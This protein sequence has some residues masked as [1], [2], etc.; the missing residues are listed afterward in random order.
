MAVR[1]N[2]DELAIR[3]AAERPAAVRRE[4]ISGF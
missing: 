2:P 3:A 1:E 4:R